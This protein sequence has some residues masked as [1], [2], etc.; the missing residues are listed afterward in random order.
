VHDTI[1]SMINELGVALNAY[2]IIICGDL[3]VPRMF[4]SWVASTYHV[5]LSMISIYKL[6]TQKV[7]MSNEAMWVHLMSMSMLVNCCK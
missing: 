5:T 7:S 3:R 1:I 4:S 2:T 6:I